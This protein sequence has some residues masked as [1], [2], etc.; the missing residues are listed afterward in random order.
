MSCGGIKICVNLI[1]A[2]LGEVTGALRES[3]AVLIVIES[4][5]LGGYAGNALGI[6]TFP[7]QPINLLH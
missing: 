7:K 2:L 1:F 5:I 3:Q 4:V 6:L